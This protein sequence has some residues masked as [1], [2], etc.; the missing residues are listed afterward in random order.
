MTSSLRSGRFWLVTM[1]AV[2]LVA[3]TFSLGQWQLRRAAQKISLQRAIEAQNN[4]SV[5]D[6]RALIAMN[7][8][9][10]IMHRQ[11]TLKGRWLAQH[12]VFLDN[13]PM[14]GKSG[15]VVITPLVLEAGGQPILVQRGWV[16]RRFDDRAR[17]PEFSTPE[18][19]V[20]VRG[21]IAGPPSRLYEFAAVES[22][23]IRQN[24]DLPLFSGQIGLPLLP[25]TLLQTGVASEGLLRDWPLPNA[26]VDKHY[27]YALQWF[28]LAALG[29]FL[30]VWF[31]IIQ[32]LRSKKHP[33]LP[34]P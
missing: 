25:V 27:G 3:T 5:L 20:T 32:P 24:L 8:I 21:R 28:G 9:A 13:R 15:F 30:Y 14:N 26:G 17:L 7:N 4:L 33:F 29:F 22:G 12:T 16:Q 23:R 11:A 34:T 31:Q 1:A 19:L 2:V 10:D 6:G 18:G